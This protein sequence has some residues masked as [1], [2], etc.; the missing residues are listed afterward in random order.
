ML[1]EEAFDLVLLDIHMPRLDGV[2]TIKA[3]RE[4]PAWADLPV[5]ALT[6]DAMSG[7]RDKYLSQGMS[8]YV[9]K[10]VEQQELITEIHR[11]LDERI[12]HRKAS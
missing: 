8:G 6:A 7:D 12:D 3:I 9:S 5:I 4:Q 10:P 2:S 1:S 11:V